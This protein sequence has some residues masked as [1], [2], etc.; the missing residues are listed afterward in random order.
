[1][2]IQSYFKEIGRLQ[3]TST[4]PSDA[5]SESDLIAVLNGTSTVMPAITRGVGRQG[6]RS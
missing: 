3:T 4:L 2:G 1:M 5:P 6:G